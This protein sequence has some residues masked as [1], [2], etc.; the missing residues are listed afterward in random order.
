MARLADL[1]LFAAQH[2]LP[3]LWIEGKS[4]AAYV[5]TPAGKMALPDSRDTVST[6]TDAGDAM[7]NSR[8]LTDGT[9]ARPPWAALGQEA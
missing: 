9:G 6:P 3:M 7:A 8:R 5:R 4:L 2:G 1:K